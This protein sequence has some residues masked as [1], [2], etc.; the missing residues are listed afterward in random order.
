MFW[1]GET[2]SEEN[3]QQKVVLITGCSS[4]IGLETA[5]EF[6]RN[7]YK[8]YASMRN[9]DKKSE[10]ENKA[11]NENLNIE[12]LE[13]D[14]NNQETIDN[15]INQIKNKENRIDVLVNN[16]GYGFM[17]SIE[18]SSLEEIK[19]QFET[20]FFG[21]IRMIKAVLP[22]MKEQK[23]GKIIN[24]S[25]VAGQIGFPLS[26]AHVSS[27]FALEGLTDSLRQELS[28]YG[29]TLALIQPGVVK[30]KFHENMKIVAASNNPTFKEMTETMIKQAEMLFQNGTEPKT[31]AEKIFDVANLDNP[32]P[33]YA[34]GEDA[35]LL[36]ENKKRMTGLEFEKSIQELFKDVM[37]LS[38]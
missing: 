27:K 18:N 38:K 10:L 9:L 6:A 14:V 32:E 21:P 3:Q 34:V 15:A 12:I 30:S 36:M 2:M 28:L 20:G 5:L 29:I 13:I 19:D 31:V 22:F 11:N 23:S 17:G 33:R 25:S 24:I 4:G 37:S 7:G 1:N 16:A 8:T 26:S 35:E